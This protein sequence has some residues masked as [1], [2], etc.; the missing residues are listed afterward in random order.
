MR[1]APRQAAVQ[2]V[3]APKTVTP[4]RTARPPAKRKG[5][6]RGVVLTFALLGAVCLAG[7][8]FAGWKVLHK[9]LPAHTISTP[10]QLL[11]Y[12]QEPK[13][14]NSMGATKLRDEIVAKSNGEASHV[15]ATVYEDS[16]GAAAKTGP[17][18]ILFIGGNLSGSAD[19]FISSFTGMLHG[20]FI[21]SAGKLGG[22]A[23]CVPGYSGHPAECAWA[24]N[25]TF[26]LI[27]SPTLSAT[28]L[29]NQLR[30]FR[31]LLEHVVK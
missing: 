28:D 1:E 6:H 2:Q 3:T 13:L 29:G 5:S 11:G 4:P 25:D 21:T 22:H 9:S 19:S 8:G 12:T 31:P 16:S 23:A 26:G 20:A 17:Q 30:A 10:Q 18:I 7:G 24:D 15:S 27:S 14:A